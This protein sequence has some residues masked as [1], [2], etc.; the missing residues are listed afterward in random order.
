MTAGNVIL[1]DHYI[2]RMRITALRSTILITLLV[3]ALQAFTGTLCAQI[4]HD[5]RN[6][7]Q[8]ALGTPP[9]AEE[10]LTRLVDYLTENVYEDRNKVRAIYRWIADR[11]AYDIHALNNPPDTWPSPDEVL[12]RRKAVCTG[13]AVLFDEM[14][15]IAGLETELIVGHSKGLGTLN[16]G[17][18]D[19]T[20]N[21]VWNAVKVDGHW[22]LFDATWGAGYITSG[23]FFIPAFNDFYFMADPVKIVY[24]H[25]PEDP[26]WQLL[27]NP[28]S[29]KQYREHVWVR[30]PFF[31][32]RLSVISHREAEITSYGELQIRLGV[33]GD[34]II[35]AA[36]KFDGNPL[37]GNHIIN[38]GGSDAQID[39]SLNLRG[40]YT[41]EVYAREKE[42]ADDRLE[43][44]MIYN[45][46]NT[47]TPVASRML[48]RQYGRFL[49]SRGNLISPRQYL[50]DEGQHQFDIVIP[51]ARDVFVVNNEKMTALHRQGDRFYGTVPVIGGDL[52]LAARF[53]GQDLDVL[54]EYMVAM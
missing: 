52:R 33:P 9:E 25:L 40:T 47:Q 39:M 4:R 11:I 48:A 50:L 53:S 36:L 15:R 16:A 44:A 17:T 12:Y 2:T 23:G 38:Y 3:L 30:V 13:Y 43:L 32:H 29:M 5:Y 18:T 8:R 19:F 54:V 37:H 22:T 28:V 34:V 6:I 21:H 7:D 45:I 14:S 49:T 41:L 42:S 1:D 20:P 26:D 35:S 10:N 51:G 31:R 27:V 46:N 24:T